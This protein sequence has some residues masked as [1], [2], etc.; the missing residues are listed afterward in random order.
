MNARRAVLLAAAV[1]VVAVASLWLPWWEAPRRPVLLVPL[2]AAPGDAET[3]SGWE[4]LGRVPATLL[5][6][7][8]IAA[9]G[10]ALIPAAIRIGLGRI[11]AAAGGGCAAS[12]ALVALITWGPSPAPGAWLAL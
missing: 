4:V 1:D 2:P 3:W 12:A 5:V 8:A 11:A 7:L 10:A 9:A 6:L